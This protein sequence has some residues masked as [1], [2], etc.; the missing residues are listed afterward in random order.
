MIQTQSSGEKID[1]TILSFTPAEIEV[2]EEPLIQIETPPS[3]Q[4]EGI[5]D[6]TLSE[7]VPPQSEEFDLEDAEDLSES[8]WNIPA[9]LFGKHLEIQKPSTDKFARPMYRYCQRKG[10]NPFEY[11]PMGNELPM[12]FAATAIIGELR[13]L[14]NEHKKGEKDEGREKSVKEKE[15]E[16]QIDMGMP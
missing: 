4:G 12:I 5:G 7:G 15:E 3:S 14:H 1:S 16:K 10:I 11:L 13:R 8:V 6:G 2:V 9:A